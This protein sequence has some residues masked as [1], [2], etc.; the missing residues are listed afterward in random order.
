MK[1]ALVTTDR[2]LARDLRASL[3]RAEG[4]PFGLTWGDFQA[5]MKLLGVKSTDRIA[6]IEIGCSQTRATG[7][8]H[9]TDAPDGIEIQEQ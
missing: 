7:R 6:S 8:I 1:P 5:A 4:V 3:V 9:R 2:T